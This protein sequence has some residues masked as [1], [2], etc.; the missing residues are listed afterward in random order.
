MKMA[1]P[2]W[3]LAGDSCISMP[4]GI[5][6]AMSFAHIAS[7]SVRTKSL[8]ETLRSPLFSYIR[9]HFGLLI[10]PSVGCALVEHK[11]ELIELSDMLV[12]G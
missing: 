9:D 7:D 3:P 2:V 1:V 12:T 10:Q 5:R 4:K 8:K 11:K 6:R